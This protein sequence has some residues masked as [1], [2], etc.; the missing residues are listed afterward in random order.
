[1]TITSPSSEKYTTQFT[2]PKNVNSE[3]FYQEI[4]FEEVTGP[5][6][7][8]KG[9]KTKLHNAFFDLDSA[10]R[11]TEFEKI[12]DR[13]EAYSAYLRSKNSEEPSLAITS[14]EKATESILTPEPVIQIAAILFD[15][16]RNEIIKASENELQKAYNSLSANTE[17]KLKIIGY[18]DA[19]GDENYNQKLSERR[20]L[21]AK[22][23]LVNKGIEAS[24]I[25]HEGHGENDPVA[26]NSNA[27]GTDNPEGRK[28]NRR[29]EFIILKN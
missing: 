14:G 13:K 20:A 16:D 29:V 11:N 23:H 24:R 12:A 15:Y 17:L 9:Y 8:V 10:I 2:V 4:A 19:K 7:K 1:M 22:R 28:L 5:D 18:T 25:I 21:K 27:D 3:D 6:G 26:P